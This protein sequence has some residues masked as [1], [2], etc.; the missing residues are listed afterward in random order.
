MQKEKERY[1]QMSSEQVARLEKL[2]EKIGKVRESLGRSLSI[3]ASHETTLSNRQACGKN[4]EVAEQRIENKRALVEKLELRL[5]KLEA[6]ST[7]IR[8]DIRRFLNFSPIEDALKDLPSEFRIAGKG[9]WRNM[10]SRFKTYQDVFTPVG[11]RVIPVTDKRLSRKEWDSLPMDKCPIDPELVPD[12]L[13]EEFE[14]ADLYGKTDIE[15]LETKAGLAPELA[16]FFAHLHPTTAHGEASYR[17]MTP[18]AYDPNHDGKILRFSF[19]SRKKETEDDRKIMQSH[20]N[21]YAAHRGVYHMDHGKEKE[22]VK[23]HGIIGRVDAINRDIVGKKKDDPKLKKL[24]DELLTEIGLIEGSRNF[25]K[26]EAHDIMVEISDIKDSLGKHNPGASCARL[27][28]ALN[29]LKKRLPQMFEKNRWNLT[30]RQII[31]ETIEKGKETMDTAFERYLELCHTIENGKDE[32]AIRDC[33]NKLP[34]LSNLRVRPFSQYAFT[35]NLKRHSIERALEA[36]DMEAVRD[37]AIDAYV[38][39]KTFQVQHEREKILRDIAASPMQVSVDELLERAIKL[40]DA[41]RSKQTF[42]NVRTCCNEAY[43]EM[44]RHLDKLVRGLE[45]YQTKALSAPERQAMYQRLKLFL[46]KINFTEVLEKLPR[47]ATM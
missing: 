3:L 10:N 16:D 11:A 1:E 6:M 8:D 30:D 19:T 29:R 17:L 13:V 24:I 34:D 12:W 42:P 47:P 20:D 38:A 31:G 21:I 45:T 25:Y 22:T 7:I 33:L 32:K 5:K 37:E 14:L 28:R 43:D 35:L 2:E 26:M 46:E 39:A 18:Q 4:T 44:A 15:K 27:V 41:V 23:I 36:A 40:C 9:E